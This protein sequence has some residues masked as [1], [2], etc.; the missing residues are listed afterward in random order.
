MGMKAL[1]LGGSG[2]I[3]SA[4]VRELLLRGYEVSATGRRTPAPTNIS[5]L[6]LAYLP[7]DENSAGQLDRWIDGHEIVIDAAAPY[8]IELFFDGEQAK[9]RTHELLEAVGRR[10][11][12]FAYVSSFTTQKR[13]AGGIADWPAQVAKELHPYFT[14]KQWIED[15]VLERSRCGLRAVFVNPTMCLG[16]WDLHRRELCL[17]PQLLRGEI[18]AVPLHNMNVI[19]VREVASGLVSALEAKC[20]GAP[21]LFSGHNISGELL[22]RWICEI[23]GVAP[24]VLSAPAAIGAYAGFCWET[25]LSALGGR[26]SYNALGAMLTYQ[27]EWMPPSRALRDLGITIRPLYETLIDS[28][29]WY[30]SVGYC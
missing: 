6:R 15:R 5:G 2:H 24:P 27:H 14:M 13:R 30:R 29:D 26:T 7:G 21:M 9:R 28:V 23:G 25:V 10:D 19:D 20:Y 8:P 22:C 11:L 3:G 12:I 18:P 17:V 16:P 4:V 1:V